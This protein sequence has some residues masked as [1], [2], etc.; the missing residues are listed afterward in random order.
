VLGELAAHGLAQRLLGTGGGAALT[1]GG[2]LAAAAVA[3][4]VVGSSMIM[5]LR[6]VERMDAARILRGD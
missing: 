5:A 1:W 6:R 3:V 4:L 2:F